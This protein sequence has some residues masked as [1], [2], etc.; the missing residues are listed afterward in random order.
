M[1]GRLVGQ[2]A[3][4]LKATWERVRQ[5]PDAPRCLIELVDVT[6]IDRSGEAVLA[7]IMSQGG[8][9]VARDLYVKDLLRTLRSELKRPA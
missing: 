4:E 9:F 6:F 1:Q 8:E 7:I 2:W 3:T 5:Q